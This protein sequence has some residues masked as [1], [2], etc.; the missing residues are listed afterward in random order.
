MQVLMWGMCLN[1]YQLTKRRSISNYF[2]PQ[3][4]FYVLKTRSLLVSIAGFHCRY[5]IKQELTD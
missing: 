3:T 1:Y 4:T 5:D 2:C